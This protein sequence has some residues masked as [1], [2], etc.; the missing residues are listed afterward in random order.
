MTTV[1]DRPL[2]L[3]KSR[4]RP[5]SLVLGLSMLSVLVLIALTVSWW[6]PFDP[7]APGVGPLQHAPDAAHWFGTDR[8]GYDV[9]SRTV[10]AT[11]TDLIITVSVVAMAAVTGTLVGLVCGYFGGVVDAIGM[12]LMEIINAVPSILLAL[13][14][15]STLGSSI[16]TVI[17]VVS[18]VAVPDYARLIRSDV[19]SRRNWDMVNGARLSGNSTRRIMFRHILPNTM[20]QIFAFLGINAATVLVMVSSLGYLGIGVQPG[21][22]EW[23]S[24]IQ[25]GQPDALAGAWWVVLFPG[26]FPFLTGLSFYLVGDGLTD[27]ND[28]KYR[29]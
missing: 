6:V 18:N 17:I 16:F 19:L 11:T 4:R 29:R 5:P 12:R 21:T 25:A 3:A 2:T 20:N 8:L 22:A 15:V 10:A 1:L 14:L 7:D 23:G 28:P 26:L 9:F 27:L 13:F 24:M